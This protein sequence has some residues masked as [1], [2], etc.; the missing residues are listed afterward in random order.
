[1]TSYASQLNFRRLYTES[2]P[3][4]ITKL[5]EANTLDQEH[6]FLDN[7]KEFIQTQQDMHPNRTSERLY[8]EGSPSC[9][10]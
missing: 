3:S 2:S 9:I 8:T 10:T 4:C 6:I 7:S 1:M 5:N